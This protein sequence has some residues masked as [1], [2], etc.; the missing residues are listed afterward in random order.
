MPKRTVN[1][2]RRTAK[3]TVGAAL[4]AI[5]ATPVNLA[6]DA[7]ILATADAENSVAPD[8]DATPVN[9]TPDAIDTAPGTVAPD[10]T[11]DAID[12]AISAIPD[13]TPVATT[14]AKPDLKAEF[15]ERKAA[16]TL[17]VL[18]LYDGESLAVHRSDKIPA[19]QAY[20]DRVA[21]PVQKAK[22]ATARD[23][24]ALLS[25]YDHLTTYRAGD[26]SA[27]FN[28][29]SFGA[30]LGAL[31]RNAS[32]HRVALSDDKQHIVLTPLGISQ[33]RNLVARRDKR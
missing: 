2:S 15:I 3:N 31:S 6:T 11:P 10:A 30:D 20:L 22:S 23:D 4:N 8:A 33:A 17:S 21:S 27:G 16:A 9:A 25:Y 32:L 19:S 26:Y 5:D 13:T 29:D 28:P 12:A 7:E 18:P 1:T 24:S 14:P